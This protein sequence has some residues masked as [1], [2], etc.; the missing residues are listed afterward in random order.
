MGNHRMR[1]HLVGVKMCARTATPQYATTP[2]S[3]SA[4]PE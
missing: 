3:L 4:S 2:I 1:S